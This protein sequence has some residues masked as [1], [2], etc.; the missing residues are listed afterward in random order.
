MNSNRNLDRPNKPRQV[1]KNADGTLRYKSPDTLRILHYPMPSMSKPLDKK[2][3]ELAL[4]QAKRVDMRSDGRTGSKLTGSC[5]SFIPSRNKPTGTDRKHRSAGKRKTN[6]PPRPASNKDMRE[7]VEKERRRLWYGYVAGKITK[8]NLARQKTYGIDLSEFDDNCL[9]MAISQW[10]H[11]NL[12][13]KAWLA[14]TDIMPMPQQKVFHA[15][16]LATL[17]YSA[18]KNRVLAK[19]IK[20]SYYFKKGN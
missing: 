18:E 11:A 4:Q 16:G 8:D 7:R 14:I 2:S 15:D 6:V 13:H 1:T 19:R 10:V 12:R 20:G 9:E 5:A 17:L 3:V